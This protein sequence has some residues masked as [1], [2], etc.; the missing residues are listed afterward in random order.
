M[1]DKKH[2]ETSSSNTVPAATYSQSTPSDGQSATSKT[3][4][5]TSSDGGTSS[6]HDYVFTGGLACPPDDIS[7]IHDYL[8]TGALEP[9]EDLLGDIPDE[10]KEQRSSRSE[11]LKTPPATPQVNHH[12]QTE[13]TA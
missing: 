10:I 1:K 12:L 6:I 7:S 5:L 8:F 11:E 13:G 4:S 3:L 2:P 9:I